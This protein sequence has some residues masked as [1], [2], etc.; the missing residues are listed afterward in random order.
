MGIKLGAPTGSRGNSP[1]AIIIE[2]NTNC[3]VRP[4]MYMANL[5]ALPGG[6]LLQPEEQ[7]LLCGRLRVNYYITTTKNEYMSI[8]MT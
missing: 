6:L 2:Y 3:N 8:S 1:D 5:H 7:G 4:S